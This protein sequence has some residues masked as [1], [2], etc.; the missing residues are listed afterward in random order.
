MRG[1]VNPNSADHTG[2][3]GEVLPL[4][5][6][7]LRGIAERYL[8]SESPGHSLQPTA[9]V[10]E[11]YLR[12]AGRTDAHWT[13]LSHFRAAASRTMR[14]VLVDHARKRAS[15]RVLD[16]VTLDGAAV[17]MAEDAI[18]LVELDE[19]LARL[20]DLDARQS[21]IVE[22]RFFGGLTVEEVAEVLDYS[23]R[24]VALQWRLA[25]AWLDRALS[26]DGAP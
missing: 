16:R 11:A 10:H 12:L 1:V 20:A 14:R 9:L 18:D 7:E 21:R 8:Q 13:G 6:D 5:Y 26:G 17:E 23:P 2:E 19:A 22:L 4:V 3:A 15:E 24:T 25:R